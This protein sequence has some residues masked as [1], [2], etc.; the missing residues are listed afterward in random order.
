M[1][2]VSIIITKVLQG[3]LGPNPGGMWQFFRFISLDIPYFKVRF[4]PTNLKV[5]QAKEYGNLSRVNAKIIKQMKN[6]RG[7]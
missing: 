4:L 1:Q 6:T 7:Y 2:H 5:Q 3:V